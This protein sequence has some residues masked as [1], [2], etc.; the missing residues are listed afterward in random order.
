MEGAIAAPKLA[1]L[2]GLVKSNNEGRQ[3]IQEGAFNQG[4]DREKI[5]DPKQTVTVTDGLVLRL[6]RK[7]VRVRLG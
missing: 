5:T 3:K 7:I 4:P 1:V 6:G 2:A